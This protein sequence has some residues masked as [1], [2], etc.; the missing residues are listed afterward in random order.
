MSYY[1]RVLTPESAPL[2]ADA[3]RA[4]LA[5]R[6]RDDVTLVVDESEDETDWTAI[7]VYTKAGEPIGLLT[8]DGLGDESGLVRDELED[9]AS[10]LA[11]ALPKSGAT[12]VKQYLKRVTTIYAVQLMAAA[13]TEDGDGV[14]GQML[15]AIRDEVGGIIQADGEG[16]SNEDG[17]QVV[18]QF[19]EDVTGPWT[20]AVLGPDKTWITFEMDLGDPAQRAAFQEGRVPEGATIEQ[21]DD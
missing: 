2:A 20:A 6:G 5:A 16:F 4:G 8:R 17:S 10:E 19:D 15:E 14:P 13:F 18:W 9:F 21:P 11:E 7:V 1:V 12:W 3:I